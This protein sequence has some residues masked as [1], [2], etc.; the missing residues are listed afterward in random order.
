MK[1]IINEWKGFLTESSISRTYEHILNHDT[2][3][4]TAFRDNTEHNKV[5]ADRSKTLENFERNNS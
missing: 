4:I 5:Y 1:K 3:F 2:A